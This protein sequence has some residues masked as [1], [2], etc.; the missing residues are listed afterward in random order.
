[1]VAPLV[2]RQ[3]KDGSSGPFL[4]TLL[5]RFFLLLGGLGLAVCLSSFLGGFSSGMMLGG[6][7]LLLALTAYALIPATNRARDDGRTATFR[8]LHLASVL[9]TLGVGLTSLLVIFV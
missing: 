4:R 7:A 9:L 1:M 6:L 2:F 3:L 8:R 5:P